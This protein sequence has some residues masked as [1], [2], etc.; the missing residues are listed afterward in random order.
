MTV[1]EYLG[2][3]KIDDKKQLRLPGP[4][5]RA[6]ITAIRREENIRAREKRYGVKRGDIV[7]IKVEVKDDGRRIVKVSRRMQVVNLYEHH[8]LLRHKTGACESYR[9]NDFMERLDR[10]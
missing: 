1:L 3:R 9:Y 7:Y 5:I 6:S 10:R 8:I 2:R 4:H